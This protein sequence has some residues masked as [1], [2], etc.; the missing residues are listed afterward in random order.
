VVTAGAPDFQY[1]VTSV[2]T[3]GAGAPDFQ[4]VIVGPGGTSVGGY[5]SLT[6][7]GQTA[8]P[9]DLTQAGGLEVDAPAGSAVSLNSVEFIE[10]ISA[11][12]FYVTD[13]SIGVKARG[14]HINSTGDLGIVLSDGG[15]ASLTHKGIFLNEAGDGNILLSTAA[16]TGPNGIELSNSGSTA[17]KI[18]PGAAGLYILESQVPIFINNVAAIAGGYTQGAVYRTGTDP[19]LLCIVH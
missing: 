12:G 14:V 17:T 8:T 18:S 19:D 13:N 6:G 11:K 1:T 10:N 5:A 2:L 9:G 15:V 16:T 7:P 3:V 4:R